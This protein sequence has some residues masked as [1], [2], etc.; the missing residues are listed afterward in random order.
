MCC[1]RRSRVEQKSNRSCNHGLRMTMANAVVAGGLTPE[2][3][4]ADGGLSFNRDA[5]VDFISPRLSLSRQGPA[6][7]CPTVEKQQQV[8]FMGQF[9]ERVSLSACWVPYERKQAVREAATICPLRVDLWPFDLEG[10]VRVTCAWATSV[11]IL[12]F[13][14]V[15]VLDLGPMYAT[16]RQTSDVKQT[17]DAHHRLTPL[18]MGGA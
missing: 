13:L 7:W 15:S 12:V 5:S 6:Q 2:L 17:S 3:C 10:G 16:D 1:V 14:G 8:A 9:G 11:P 4:C 18:P